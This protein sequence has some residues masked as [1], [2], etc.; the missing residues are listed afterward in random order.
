MGKVPL[1]YGPKPYLIF[2]EPELPENASNPSFMAQLE[3][4]LRKYLEYDT[5]PVLHDRVG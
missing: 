1:T 4:D 5:I 3:R 2:P